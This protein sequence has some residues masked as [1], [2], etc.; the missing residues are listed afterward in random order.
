MTLQNKTRA[1][2][3]A[4]QWLKLPEKAACLIVKDMKIAMNLIYG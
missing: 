1:I 3:A 4:F 2:V